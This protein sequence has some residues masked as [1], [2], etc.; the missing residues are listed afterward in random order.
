M[1][2]TRLAALKY[3]E[4]SQTEIEP[5]SFV[6]AGGFLTTGPPGKSKLEILNKELEN[7]KEN[8]MKMKNIITEM[9]NI[10]EGLINRLHDNRGMDHQAGTLCPGTLCP[11]Q[12]WLKTDHT[13]NTVIKTEKVTDRES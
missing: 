9:Q 1:W 7:I 8:Q 6:L 2:H 3:V 13:S 4:S 5:I 10:L 12:D 11:K